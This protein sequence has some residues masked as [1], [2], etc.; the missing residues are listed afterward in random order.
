MHIGSQPSWQKMTGRNS[1]RIKGWHPATPART[2]ALICLLLSVAARGAE[3]SA[4]SPVELRAGDRVVFLGDRMIE[5]EQ[6]QAWVEVMLTSRFPD[7]A[8]TFR[9]LG[10]SGDTPAGDS[11]FG[12]SLLQAS[13]EPTDEGWKGLVQQIEDAKPTVVF[14][15]YGMASSFDG[16]AGLAKFKTD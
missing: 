9:N 3:P 15:G 14:V 2:P 7:R 13:K 8:I 10:W 16:A 6:Y 5:G 12:L 1:L 4:P 11:R